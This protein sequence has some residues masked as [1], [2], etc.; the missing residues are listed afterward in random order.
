MTGGGLTQTEGNSS[1]NSLRT[2][3]EKRFGH[4][5]TVLGNF[6]WQKIRSD[7]HDPL[8]GDIGGY[9]APLLAGFGIRQDFNLADFD[10]PRIFHV[11]GSYELPFG[12]GRQ[13]ASSAHGF[14]KQAIVGWS[15]NWIFTIQDGQPFTVNCATGTTT[16]FGCNALVVPGQNLYANS[17][18]NHFV[19]YA[20][21]SNPPLATKIGQTDITPL[22]GSPTQALG[23]PFRS[24]QLSLFKQFQITEHTHL[25]FRAECFNLTNTPNFS[26]PSTLNYLN[27]VSFGKIASIRDNPNDAR[28]L[29]FG[30]KFYW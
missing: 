1:Y 2:T 8:E 28:E 6:T 22:G 24:L 9:R 10:V 12:P 17:N 3:Y 13:F 23:P 25:E 5:L 27:A 16:G 15:L 7:A 19:N 26:N 30:L 14:V 29:Q 4:G 18:V 11:S 21:F 20:A